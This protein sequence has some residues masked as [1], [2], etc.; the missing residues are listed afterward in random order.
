[1]ASLWHRDDIANALA[2]L[3][4]ATEGVAQ[5]VPTDGM[6]LYRLGYVTALNNARRAFG[7]AVQEVQSE[8]IVPYGDGRAG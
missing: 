1:M 7:I 5:Y 2:A 3:D 8:A 6:A 4:N